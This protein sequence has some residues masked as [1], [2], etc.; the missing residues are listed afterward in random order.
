MNSMNSPQS[1]S[2]AVRVGQSLGEAF[3]RIQERI[4]ERAYQIFQGRD[5]DQ[6][7]SLTD[8]LNAQQQELTPVE[9]VVKNQ[10][11]NVVVEGNLK[12]FAAKEI[13]V[14][15]SG[16]ELRVFGSHTESNTGEESDTSRSTS[17]S[18]YFYQ[19][20]TLP[21]AIDPDNAT[22][23]LYKNGKLSITLPKKAQAK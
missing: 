7:D 11:K 18:A 4:R 15:V 6:G 17:E 19:S 13:E 23:K 5:P 1:D 10:K 22:A 8:W 2:P 21:C 16:D 14:D 9:L 12:G 3:E 20:V